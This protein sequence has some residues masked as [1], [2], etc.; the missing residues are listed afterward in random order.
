MLAC[1]QKKHSG[2]SRFPAFVCVLPMFEKQQHVW[3]RAHQVITRNDLFYGTTQSH[4]TCLR[5]KV[6]LFSLPP[7]SI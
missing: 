3:P 7:K 6:S 2:M 1:I 5:L 4:C